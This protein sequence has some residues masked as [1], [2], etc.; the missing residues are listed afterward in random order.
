MSGVRIEIDVNGFNEFRSQPALVNAIH[1][2]AEQIAEAAGG[3]PDFIVRDFPDTRT[4]ARS[5]VVTATEKGMRAE[6][7][8]RALTKALDAGRG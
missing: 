1:N 5:I 2:A 6:A 7:E 4:R 3:S 8:S